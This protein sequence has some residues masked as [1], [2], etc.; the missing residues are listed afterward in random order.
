MNSRGGC[1]KLDRNDQPCSLTLAE[2]FPSP[3][4]PALSAAGI[5]VLTHLHFAPGSLLQTPPLGLES[6]RLRP[7][8]QEAIQH[9]DTSG[10]WWH[11]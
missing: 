7:F 4:L 3:L 9:L 5:Q 1:C 6:G 2:E 11:Q 8:M 10:W